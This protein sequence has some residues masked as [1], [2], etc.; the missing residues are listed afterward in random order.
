MEKLKTNELSL[1]LNQ[2]LRNDL[3]DNFD[4]IQKGVDGQSD[5]L[6]KQ[7]LDMLSLIHI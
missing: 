1:G 5:S 6:N 7:I 2:T 4:K 3:V